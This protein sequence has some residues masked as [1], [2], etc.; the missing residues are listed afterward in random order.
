MA[1]RGAVAAGGTRALSQS[2]C[3]QPPSVSNSHPKGPIL[4]TPVE[5]LMHM[6][7]VGQAEEGAPISAHVQTPRRSCSLA[8]PIWELRL[9]GVHRVQGAGLS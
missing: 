5:V 8:P 7:G 6:L 2:R 4:V 9:M 1:L 3:M